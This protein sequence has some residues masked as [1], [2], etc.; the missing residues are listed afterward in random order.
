MTNFVPEDYI[1]VEERLA[2]FRAENPTC[3]LKTVC[4][5]TPSGVIVRAELYN[6]AEH[7]LPL[8]TAHAYAGPKTLSEEKGLE[9]TET[10]ALGR[11]LKFAGYPDSPTK[12]KD[13]P[14]TGEN[15]TSKPE[16]EAPPPSPPSGSAFPDGWP[17]GDDKGKPLSQVGDGSLEWF[18]SKY[19][20]RD[21]RY[22]ATD[23]E[24]RAEAQAEI[25]RR[26]AMKNAQD[27]IPF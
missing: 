13:S 18:V 3:L 5:V 11:A 17:F 25:D 2:R 26:K 27:E 16:G 12:Q 19:K 1:P 7:A 24:R 10:A 6:R 8:T 23:D 20:T 21:E 9:N 22:R 4:E 15:A 14:R